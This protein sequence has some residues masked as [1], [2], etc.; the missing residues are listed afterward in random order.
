[1][2]YFDPYGK[3]QPTG[4]CRRG[5]SI[6]QAYFRYLLKVF[7]GWISFLTASF[8]PGKRAIHDLATGSIMVRVK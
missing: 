4:R 5:P 8:N 6:L 3:S 7:L 2:Y 1:M